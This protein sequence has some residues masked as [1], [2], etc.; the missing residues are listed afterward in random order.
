[1]GDS[2]ITQRELLKLLQNEII[3]SDNILKQL[4][5]FKQFTD[6]A[7]VNDSSLII[8]TITPKFY[9]IMLTD[10]FGV[11]DELAITLTQ[12][13]IAWGIIKT[14]VLAEPIDTQIQ[15]LNI[16]TDIEQ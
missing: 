1:M 12:I 15:T 13:L 5:L 2:I 14:D 10:A 7:S 8:R 6:F 3:L 16:D 4:I 9:E 11:S